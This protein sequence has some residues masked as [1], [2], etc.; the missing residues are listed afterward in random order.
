MSQTE[1]TENVKKI[2]VRKY[3]GENHLE[4]VVRKY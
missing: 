1:E 3:P 2:L 4:D